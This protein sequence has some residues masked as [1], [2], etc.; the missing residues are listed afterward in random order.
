MS[1]YRGFTL[2]TLPIPGG[3]SAKVEMCFDSYT[4]GIKNTQGH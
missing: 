2:V 4:P 1:C 3:P